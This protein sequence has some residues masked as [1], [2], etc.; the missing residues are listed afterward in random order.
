MRGNESAMSVHTL[1]P[2]KKF[3]DHFALLGRKFIK[4]YRK[5]DNFA[6]VCK[7]IEALAC[8]EQL[9]GFGDGWEKKPRWNLCRMFV[10]NPNCIGAGNLA[11]MHAE[12]FA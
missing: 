6:K 12:Q 11:A 7:V 8:V 10:G 5:I 2:C 1:G 3:V 9:S 4:V